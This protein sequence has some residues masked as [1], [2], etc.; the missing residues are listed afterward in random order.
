[1]QLQM[2]F[3]QALLHSELG[4]RLA[5]DSAERSRHRGTAAALLA[6]HGANAELVHLGHVPQAS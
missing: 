1:M 4:R 5:G 6:A 2:P 3:D